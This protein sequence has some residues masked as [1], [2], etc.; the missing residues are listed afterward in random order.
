MI[1][2][3]ALQ[4][5]GGTFILKVFDIFAQATIDILY[6]LSSLY[7]KCYIIKPNT[8]RNANSEKY[9][10]CKLFKL[11]DTTTLINKLS[12]FLYGY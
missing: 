2:A 1:Y 8:S 4:K 6:I 5:Q 9:I 11:N 12:A 3:I 7:E 10:V